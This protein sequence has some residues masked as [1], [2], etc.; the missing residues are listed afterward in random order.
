MEMLHVNCYGGRRQPPAWC[1]VSAHICVFTIRS[2]LHDL[3]LKKT[4]ALVKDLWAGAI[5]LSSIAV[6]SMCIHSAAEV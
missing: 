5:P 1:D 3:Q 6:I 4:K 2:C